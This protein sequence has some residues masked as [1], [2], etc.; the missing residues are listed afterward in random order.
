MINKLSSFVF[1][2]V[3]RYFLTNF[4]TTLHITECFTSIQGEGVR[5][6]TPSHFIRLHG[7]SIKCPWCDSKY[8][9]TE[10][11][12]YTYH[13]IV[14]LFNNFK[15]SHPNVTNLV[16][17][18]GEPLEQ[19]IRSLVILGKALGWTVEIETNGLLDSFHHSNKT[20]FKFIDLFVVSPKLLTSS[21]ITKYTQQGFRQFPCYKTI[22]KFVAE[23]ESDVDK[24][25]SF[26]NESSIDKSKVWIMPKGIT[27]DDIA[28][29]SA[30]LV[31]ICLC[32]NLKLSDRFHIMIWGT[33]RG[34]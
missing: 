20:F 24:I 17:T 34:V 25:V 11:T 32:Y 26:C 30:E 16:I 19:D 1:K 6:G 18:G 23:S 13:T 28:K 33:K 5:Q 12:M 10:Y 8:S 15:Y 22:F 27:R 31:S 9:W 2:L 3:S 21:H 7:C 14:E 29:T 4:Y